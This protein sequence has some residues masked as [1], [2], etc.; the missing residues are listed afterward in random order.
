MSKKEWTVSEI[1]A[2]YKG[3]RRT[4]N[5][6][7]FKNK[8][9]ATSIAA[10]KSSRMKKWRE[11]TEF[12]QGGLCYPQ[13][14]MPSV[15]VSFPLRV[16]AHPSDNR[17][18]CVPSYSLSVLFT[19]CRA[20]LFATPW[21]AAWTVIFIQYE[22]SFSIIWCQTGAVSISFSPDKLEL[23]AIKFRYSI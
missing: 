16:I 8:S 18:V 1:E 19:R 3:I 11:T 5:T 9:K 14:H 20:R 21:T 12:I 6:E 15:S 17:D 7:Y 13:R 4:T 22:Y 10:K 23:Q 2:N